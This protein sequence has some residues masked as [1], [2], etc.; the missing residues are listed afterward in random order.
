MAHRLFFF[1][2]AFSFAGAIALADPGDEHTR[3]ARVSYIEGHVSFQH[4]SDADWS[5]ASINLPLEPGDR[6]YTGTDGRAEIEFDDGSVV[7]LAEKTDVEFLSLNENI[8]QLRFLVGLGTLTVSSGLDFEVDTPAA[9]FNTLRKGI[10]R[11]DVHENGECDAIVRKGELEAAN[12]QFTRRI[13]SGQM[14]HVSPGDTSANEIARYEG[15][16][17]W[18]E[19]NDRRNADINAYASRRYLPDD[20]YMGASDLDRYGHWVSIESYGDAWVPFAVDA[21]WSPYSV[22]RWCYRPF[23]GWTWVSYEP[24]GWLPYHYG[25][26][27]FSLPFGW[28]WLPGP[29]FAFNFWS[30]GLVAFYSGPGW[31]SWC[32]LGPGDYYYVGNYHFN[33]RSYGY[34]LN[35]LQALQ[36]RAPGD[37]F[38]RNSRGAFRAAKV[39]QFTN[40][41][42]GDRKAGD[43]F[44]NVDQP[45]K[46]GTLVKELH[47]IKP[48]SRSY[49]AAP[50]IVA[51]RPRA[52]NA[53]P[54]IVRTDPG[55]KSGNP[56]RF[57]RITNPQIPPLSSTRSQGRN[58]QSSGPDMEGGPGRVIQAPQSGGYVRTAPGAPGDRRMTAPQPPNEG[59]GAGSREGE[60]TQPEGR[61]LSTA[62]PN[63]QNVPS[64]SGREQQAPEARPAPAPRYERQAPAPTPAPR[65]DRQAPEARPAP[66]PAPAPHNDRQAPETRPA[67]APAPAPH[68]DRQAPETNPTPKE[69]GQEAKPRSE[70]RSLDYSYAP[71]SNSATFW[72][73]PEVR[74]MQA[75][76]I[77]RSQISIA[78]QQA[79]PSLGVERN[80]G[81]H[82]NPAFSFGGSNNFSGSPGGGMQSAPQRNSQDSGSG[83]R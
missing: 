58:V 62:P 63:R 38:N 54:A 44:D 60:R 22:G 77:G 11:F 42:F 68:N 23:W 83:R 24:W 78:P 20:V 47:P 51:M 71:G 48:T 35:Q 16:D 59:S 17:E 52:A 76:E 29:A 27:Y 80:G 61:S 57:T 46:L 70:N 2:L 74:V 66:A 73:R 15:R 40:G 43:R 25:R 6:V 10:Y 81:V 14:L 7:R 49:S 9:A 4:E 50:E 21:Y 41:S 72:S 34:Q 13:S 36:T 82:V 5:A 18:D 53:L 28:C 45:W 32:P 33:R 26:W 39:E 69:S 8:I 65:N 56:D 67:P 37:L 79:N 19:W 30:P 1:V 75:P 31:I 3:I 12:N 55:I 64:T